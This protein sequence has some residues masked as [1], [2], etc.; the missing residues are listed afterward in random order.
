MSLEERVRLGEVTDT[1]RAI[2]DGRCRLDDRSEDGVTGLLTKLKTLID[3]PDDATFPAL[4]RQV[5]PSRIS[6]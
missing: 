6:A 1:G 4:E 3:H 2:A 5:L